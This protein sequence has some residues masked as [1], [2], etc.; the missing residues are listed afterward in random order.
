MSTLA[1]AAYRLGRVVRKPVNPNQG[2]SVNQSVNFYCIKMFLT[3]Y[4][5]YSLKSFKI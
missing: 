5:L 4:L 1:S 2:L 3:G